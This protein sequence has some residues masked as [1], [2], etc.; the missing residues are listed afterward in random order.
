MLEIDGHQ[1]EIVLL[2]RMK[3]RTD[4]KAR[5]QCKRIGDNQRLMCKSDLKG[6]A[7]ISNKSVSK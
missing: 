6:T 5:L 1:C 4:G 7:V 3:Q 2:F